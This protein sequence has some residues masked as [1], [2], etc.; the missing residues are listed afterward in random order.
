M[1]RALWEN[2]VDPLLMQEVLLEAKERLAHMEESARDK[3]KTDSE[4]AS[5][6]KAVAELRRVIQRHLN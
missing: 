1:K 2:L 5:L 6:V 3:S 4:R